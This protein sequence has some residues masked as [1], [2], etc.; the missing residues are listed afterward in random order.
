MQPPRIERPIARLVAQ[1]CALLGFSQRTVENYGYR[2]ARFED[3]AGCSALEA[4]MEQAAAWQA[5]CAARNRTRRVLHHNHCALVF[6]WRHLRGG[7][8]DRRLV[9]S[10]RPERSPPGERASPAELARLF[11]ALRDDRQRRFCQFVYATGLRASE[12]VEVRMR[13]LDLVGRSLV[14]R[15]GKGRRPRRTILPDGII[16]VLRPHLHPHR[17]DARLFTPTMRRTDRR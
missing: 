7:E 3:W 14:V 8:L 9:P 10:V 6:L 15:A 13:D 5:A 12:A 11:A 2:L 1:R 4:S 16:A 17:P